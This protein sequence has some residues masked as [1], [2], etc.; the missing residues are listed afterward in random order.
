M[1][2]YVKIHNVKIVI[3]AISLQKYLIIISLGCFLLCILCTEVLRAQQEKIVLKVVGQDKNAERL[4]KKY[5]LPS[6][7][8]NEDTARKALNKMLLDFQKKAYWEASLAT[9]EIHEDKNI[10]ALIKIGTPYHWQ[11][12][13]QGNLDP[14]VAQQVNFKEK[15]YTQRPVYQSEIEKLKENILKYSE[16]HGF[17]FATFKLDSLVINTDKKLSASINYQQG[18]KILF[19]TLQIRGNVVIKSKFLA[20]FLHIKSGKIF[21]QNRI[22]K[23]AILLKTLPYLKLAKS[24]SVD[25]RLDYA[26]PV[27]ELKK[28]K[29]NEISGILGFL[30]N[31]NPQRAQSLLLTGSVNLSLHNLF[32]AGK[33]LAFKWERL[34]ISTQRLSLLYEHPILLGA[35][36]D[37]SLGFNLLRQ[38]SSF[39]NRLL[40]VSLF[41]RLGNGARVKLNLQDRKSTLGEANLF[42]ELDFLPQISQVGYFS[43]G[44]GYEWNNLDDANFA[45]KGFKLDF[46]FRTGAKRIQR[47][48]FVPDSL[49]EGIQLRSTQAVLEADIHKYFSIG[50]K[51]VVKTRIQAGYIANENL[52]L[53]ELTQLGGLETLR[54]HNENFFFASA[55][56]ITT[57]EY[58]WYFEPSSYLF[59]FY[60]QG[61]LQRRVQRLSEFDSPAGLGVGINFSV[62]AGVFQLV[63]A[64]GQS[65][66]EPFAFNRAKIH[67]GLLSRF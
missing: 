4:V 51:G 32:N 33:H 29:A 3:Q 15:Y 48:P 6:K 50:K 5:R 22:D 55:H 41:Y 12:L 13:Q 44:L 57:L 9:W 54:G 62:S 49:Y 43:Y 19:D 34:Q 59:M 36:I 20:K 56:S 11:E 37:V 47:N 31:E 64:L 52:F 24:P 46:V 38:D 7:Y 53:N 21:E 60:D 39:V 8:P 23:M 66:N 25:F 40:N 42:Q 27:I 2:F 18:P 17:P 35:D 10:T 63:Y 65:K 16:N 58:Q 28:Q 14:L 30:P 61:F 1:L 26:Y 45:H 67:F